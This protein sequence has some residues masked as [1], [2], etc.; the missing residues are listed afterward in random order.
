M[1]GKPLDE[2]IASYGP[3]VMNTHDELM[4]AFKDVNDGKM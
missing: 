3:F 4:Q 2:P 1:G